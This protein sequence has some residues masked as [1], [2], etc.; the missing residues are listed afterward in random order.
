MIW[1]T[2]WAY[3]IPNWRS[4]APTLPRNG[5]DLIG[6]WAG[7]ESGEEGRVR[8]VRRGPKHCG[9]LHDELCGGW[10]GRFVCLRLD[11]GGCLLSLDVSLSLLC[12]LL[13]RAAA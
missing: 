13:Y 3:C 5:G 2:G 1:G 4:Q 8:L 10:R 11:V 12:L 9:R 6:W 7:R